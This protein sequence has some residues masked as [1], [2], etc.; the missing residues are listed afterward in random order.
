MSFPGGRQGR[1]FSGIVSRFSAG[2]RSGRTSLYRAELV[3][4]FW[5]L[6][7]TTDRRIFQ[8]KSVPDILRQVI[9]SLDVSYRLQGSYEPRN[10]CVQYRETDFD[11]ACRLMEEEGIYYY[12]THSAGGHQLVLGDSPA[13][14]LD[15]LGGPLTYDPRTNPPAGSSTVDSW[16]KSQELRSGKVTLGDH[17]FELPQDRIEASA[18]VQESATAGTVTHQLQVPATANLE[19]YD[20]PGGYA[21]RFDDPAQVPAD[22]QRTAAIRIQQEAASALEI[23]GSSF[24]GNLIAGHR[25]SLSGHFDG[26]GPYVLTEVEH[27]ASLPDPG[28]GRLSYSNT[29]RCSPGSLPYRPRRVT[30]V[31]TAAGTETAVVVGPPGEEVFTDAHGRIKVQFHWDREGR[32]DENS[33]CWVRVVQPVGQAPPAVPRIGQEVVIAFE[34]GDPDRPIVIGRHWP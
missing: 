24:A 32:H 2:D 28:S 15:V 14:H 29:F 31:P 8:Q 6:T 13:G 3:P 21:E 9:G 4:A 16:T 20:Y 25:F 10:Y 18:L 26:D 30:P 34:D 27:S 5:L 11:F 19:L 23:N 12:F 7:K 1:Y 33:S 17:H 22:A